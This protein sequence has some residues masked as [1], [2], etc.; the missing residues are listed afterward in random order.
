MW[1]WPTECGAMSALVCLSLLPV[2]VNIRAPSQDVCVSWWGGDWGLW[3]WPGDWDLL[4]SLSLWRSV[5]D[6]TGMRPDVTVG[7]NP[8]A[9]VSSSHLVCDTSLSPRPNK[10]CGIDIISSHAGRRRIWWLVMSTVSWCAIMASH[11]V[12][13]PHTYFST[14]RCG[15]NWKP[16]CILYSSTFSTY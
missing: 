1:A 9:I 3:V 7:K 2:W 16:T 13:W 4:L 6:N 12:S 15:H 5:W 8:K 14:V 11:K 10:Q